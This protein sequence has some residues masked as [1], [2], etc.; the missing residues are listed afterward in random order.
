MDMNAKRMK[1]RLQGAQAQGRLTEYVLTKRQGDISKAHPD[2]HLLPD[3]IGKPFAHAAAGFDAFAKRLNGRPLARVVFEPTSP[4][5]RLFER[6]LGRKGLPL[7]KVN[8][9]R[10]R[11][12]AEAIDAR[13][14]AQRCCDHES[15]HTTPRKRYA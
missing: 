1:M 14:Q 7:A 9:R 5:H 13:R 15:R 10:A 8:P 3:G 6:A 4:Y 2:V 11:L 12:F